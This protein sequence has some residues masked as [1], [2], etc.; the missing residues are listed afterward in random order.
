MQATAA[1]PQS[2]EAQSRTS[3]STV[4]EHIDAQPILAPNDGLPLWLRSCIGLSYAGVGAAH[5][6]VG[7]LIGATEKGLVLAAVLVLLT[8]N[9][10]SLDIWRSRLSRWWRGSSYGQSAQKSHHKAPPS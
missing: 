2:Y 5:L 9:I 8:I 3:A 6:I 4:A 7:A 10:Y 1:V